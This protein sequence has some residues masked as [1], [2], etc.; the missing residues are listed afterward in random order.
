MCGVAGEPPRDSGTER[1]R[2]GHLS[3]R[4]PAA[5]LVSGTQ[6]HKCQRHV[7]LVP[8][9][10]VRDAPFVSP[11]SFGGVSARE[12]NQGGA[13]DDAEANDAA[14]LSILDGPAECLASGLLLLLGVT[15]GGVA[16]I[17]LT[18]DDFEVD[19]PNNGAVGEWAL[20]G[21][22]VGQH[23]HHGPLQQ[24]QRPR[25]ALILAGRRSCGFGGPVDDKG[26]DRLAKLVRTELDLTGSKR[27]LLTTWPTAPLAQGKPGVRDLPGDIAV[28][29]EGENHVRGAFLGGRPARAGLNGLA[30]VVYPEHECAG[31]LG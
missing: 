29:E 14:R 27:E 22:L 11:P 21:A 15:V 17:E 10:G 5:Q 4:V 6:R 25:P 9:S 24:P 3:R 28:T 16:L 18:A 12:P 26:G 19:R 8:Q 23:G 13:I 7:P 1:D 20:I 30:E 2:A 31:G